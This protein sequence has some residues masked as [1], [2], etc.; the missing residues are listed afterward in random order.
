MKVIL[1][2]Q[3]VMDSTTSR[4]GQGEG[5]CEHYNEPLGSLKGG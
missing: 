5:S 4:Q 3:C 2:Q 1:K